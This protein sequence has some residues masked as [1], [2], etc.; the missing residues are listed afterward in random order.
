[1]ADCESFGS[2]LRRFPSIRVEGAW[3]LLCLAGFYLAC[4]VQSPILA[5]FFL[6]FLFHAGHE[7][8]HEK[9]FR[10]SLAN[11][12]FGTFCFSCQ[13]HNYFLL[14]GAHAEHHVCGREDKQHCL[15]DHRSNVPSLKVY[16]EYYAFLFGWNYVGLVAAGLLLPFRGYVNRHYPFLKYVFRSA[17]IAQLAVLL[18]AV[19]VFWTLGFT[20]FILYGLFA[21]YWGMSQNVAHYA[22][23]VGGPYGKYASRTFRVHPWLSTA[24]F[25]STF[26]H[27]EH[28][29]APEISSNKLGSEVLS[30]RIQGAIGGRPL[31]EYG[32]WSYVRC[33]V[34]QF[35]GPFPNYEEWRECV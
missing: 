14:R 4:L 15:I 2:G 10:S 13:L 9:L 32:I 1:M 11:R 12:M 7:A 17:L 18:H 20:A 34:R 5:L 30:N 27:L 23:P 8:G 33:L 28:H 22:L 29:V 35:R 24:F 31:V 25:H 19:F 16:L 6:I 26:F 21:I 3:G